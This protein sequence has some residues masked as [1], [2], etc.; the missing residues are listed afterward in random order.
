MRKIEVSNDKDVDEDCGGVGV[1]VGE[2][3]LRK[4]WTME[5]TQMLVTGCNR[6]RSCSLLVVFSKLTCS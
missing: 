1:G 2:K 4:K 6:V 3:K 5:E